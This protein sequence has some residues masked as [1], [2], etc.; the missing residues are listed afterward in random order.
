MI[1]AY[2]DME[3]AIQAMKSG[4]YDYIRKPLDIDEIE[5]SVDRAIEVLTIEQHIPLLDA[6]EKPEESEVIIGKSRCMLDIFKKSDYY[7]NIAHRF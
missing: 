6:M 7:A 3:T 4:A 2:Q 1:T 5:T